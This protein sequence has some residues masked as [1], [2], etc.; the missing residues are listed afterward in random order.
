M[1]TQSAPLDAVLV[2]QHT[3]EVLRPLSR[4]NG[5]PREHI[6]HDARASRT[7][8]SSGNP[9]PYS[10]QKTMTLSS[11]TLSSITDETTDI[12]SDGSVPSIDA[13]S[14]GQSRSTSNVDPCFPRMVIYELSRHQSRRATA[15]N[16]INTTTFSGENLTHIDSPCPNIARTLS[17]A[18]CPVI[19]TL[20][21]L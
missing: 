11:T 20:L 9:R 4:R 10:L 16:N 18:K 2:P 1:L 7:P 19:R 3:L 6:P 12:I 21:H 8:R 5:T 17:A 15:R 14:T 13:P